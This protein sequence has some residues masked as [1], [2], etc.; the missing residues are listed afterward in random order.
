MP[1]MGL[2]EFAN[3]SEINKNLHITQGAYNLGRE[4]AKRIIL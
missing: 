2:G 3:N 1:L 4:V